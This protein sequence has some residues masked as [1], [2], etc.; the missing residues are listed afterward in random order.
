MYQVGL[1]ESDQHVAFFWRTLE[2]FSK[3]Q[4]RMFIKFACNQERIPATCPC[5]DGQKAHVPPYPMK[6]APPD[7]QQGATLHL[8]QSFKIIDGVCAGQPDKRFIRAE[9]CLFML[10]LPQ[11][12]TQVLA[13]FFLCYFRADPTCFRI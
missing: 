3:E 13:I 7:G 11:Y 8:S 12:S 5:Q 10:K 1:S 4:L 9:T 2:S 6:I